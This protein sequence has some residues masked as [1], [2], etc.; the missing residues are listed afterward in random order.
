[1]IVLGQ[2]QRLALHDPAAR[3]ALFAD[4]SIDTCQGDEGSASADG[5]G[6]NPLQASDWE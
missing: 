4:V 5:P 6:R 2:E 1:M 3:L